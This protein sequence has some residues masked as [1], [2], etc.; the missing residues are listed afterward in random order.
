[1]QA[2]E[3]SAKNP[4][5]LYTGLSHLVRNFGQLA[6]GNVGFLKELICLVAGMPL[7]GK[8]SEVVVDQPL[9][10]NEY[11]KCMELIFCCSIPGLAR[12]RYMKDRVRGLPNAIV[13]N[14]CM[15]LIN[16]ISQPLK[17]GNSLMMALMASGN[18]VSIS[19]SDMKA[20]KECVAAIEAF[21]SSPEDPDKCAS[22]ITELVR[23][24]ATDD[25][26]MGVQVTELSAFT[27]TQ[28]ADSEEIARED[29]AIEALRVRRADDEQDNKDKSRGPGRS[30][31]R[32][33]K[34]GRGRGR[35]NRN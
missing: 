30:D 4:I 11:V 1:M 6:S 8:E 16:S 14:Y 20:D 19:A 28:D 17:Q 22:A 13:S 5:V 9:T 24:C 12:T 3:A 29:E 25:V 31:R 10:S 2:L 18:R 35:R 23:F 32:R 33:R 26:K 27:G 15:H 34:R 7:S 21:N